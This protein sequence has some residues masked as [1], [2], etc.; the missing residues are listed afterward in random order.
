MNR[1]GNRAGA[2]GE[3]KNYI[4]LLGLVVVVEEEILT[5]KK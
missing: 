2:V 1:N 5:L 3:H 4:G